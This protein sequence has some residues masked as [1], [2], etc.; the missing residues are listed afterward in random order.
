[1]PSSGKIIRFAGPAIFVSIA[2]PIIGMVD[3]S[4]VGL[5]GGSISLAALGPATTMID[6]AVYLFMFITVATTN[7]VAQATAFENKGE[8]SMV[9]RTSIRFALQCG[10][11]LSTC[12]LIFAPQLL[13]AY[14]GEQAS[15]V[16]GPASVY[17]RIR[18][19]S[20]PTMLVANAFNAALLGS[21]DSATPSRVLGIALTL[22]IFGD[23]L[24]VC[25][26]K[27]GLQGAALAT[28]LSQF[29]GFG[30]LVKS[31]NLF[32]NESAWRIITKS[33]DVGDRELQREMRAKFM[34]F[35]PS[36]LLVVIGKIAVFAFMTH[37]AACLSPFYLAAHQVVLSTFFLVAPFSEMASQTFQA[38][39]PEIE[40]SGGAAS[41]KLLRRLQG[42]FFALVV[43]VSAV[44]SLLPLFG[45]RLFTS[46][47]AVIAAL[48]PLA[49]LLFMSAALHS[50]VCSAEGILF[51]RRELGF[52]GK[53]YAL[54][55]V[56]MPYALIT[57]KQKSAGLPVIWTSFV[58][59]QF[60]R[61]AILNCK[62]HWPRPRPRTP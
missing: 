4:A 56:A 24:L 60:V 51:A 50:L 20:M 23:I 13:R 52:L 16:I 43:A 39:L 46:D 31:F 44:G 18:A 62:V 11:G 40:G 59:F 14:V 47:V 55:A 41:G 58:M 12:L 53:V 36:V 8:R 61:A 30:L 15:A 25:G 29:V 3:S 49:P 45:A 7:L 42:S 48:K 17:V 27:L 38:F 19:L 26:V 33:E 10:F 57:L 1:M 5:T 34:A 54:S 2:G 35:V 9:L 32:F 21:K 6:G 37:V 28:I 22:N